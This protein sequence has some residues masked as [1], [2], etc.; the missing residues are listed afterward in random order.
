MFY[1]EDVK[2]QLK[3]FGKNGFIKTAPQHKGVRRRPSL[4]H[5]DKRKA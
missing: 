3:D 4:S 5:T 2:I 1:K